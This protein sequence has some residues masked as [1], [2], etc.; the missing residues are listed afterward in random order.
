MSTLLSVLA[1][2]AIVNSQ[3]YSDDCGT[4]S[5]TVGTATIS[6]QLERD[7]AN[8]MVRITLT[9]PNDAWYGMV[10]GSGTMS[11]Y[12]ITGEG[13]T[14][15]L[16]ERSISFGNQGTDMATSGTRTATLGTNGVLVLERPYRFND[17]STY[18]DF[19]PL[20]SC[21]IDTIPLAGALGSAFPMAKH[22]STTANQVFTRTCDCPTDAPSAATSPPSAG[23]TASPNDATDAPSAATNPPSAG[24]TAS[25]EEASSDDYEICA[26]SELIDDITLTLFRDTTNKMARI[27]ISG[28]NTAWFGYGF[29]SE[30]M[31]GAYAVTVEGADSANLGVVE[32]VLNQESAPGVTK[33]YGTSSISTD[34]STT[35]GIL[36]LAYDGAGDD[37]D[38]TNFLTCV[39]DSINIIAASGSTT[40]MGFHTTYT[41][42]VNGNMEDPKT[43]TR[44]ASCT[45]EEPSS[46]ANNIFN[47]IYVILA[48]FIASLF[49]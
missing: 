2:I 28:P 30:T 26:T 9:G 10:I 19:T 48:V 32:R 36:D 40:T 15:A 14:Y 43:L 44:Q 21:Q 45:C 16:A 17:D 7:F 5:F 39:D 12:A 38:F 46:S 20:L 37:F 35:T 3:T 24:P 47:G 23:P 34:G 8:S 18:F 33:T 25:P 31:T 27:Q 29:G 1:T 4:S 49:N 13:T 6:M 22:I 41:P 42:K 11:G